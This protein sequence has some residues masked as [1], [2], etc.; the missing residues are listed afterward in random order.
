MS[1]DINFD[2]WFKLPLKFEFT[3]NGTVHIQQKTDVFDRNNNYTKWDASIAKKLLKSNNLQLKLG[4][5][6]ILNQNI[7]FNRTATTN[8]ITEN[9]FLTLQRYWFAGIQY[10]I[11]KNP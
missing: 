8:I 10:N 4:V 1:G 2:A 9:R 11:S 7:G 3:T 5:N 6:D